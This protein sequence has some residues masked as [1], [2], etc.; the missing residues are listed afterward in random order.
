LT[1][2]T[3]AP[4]RKA[5]SKTT[6]HRILVAQVR[7][8]RTRNK[9]I[10]AAAHVFASKGAEAPVIDDFIQAAGVSRGTFYNYFSTVAE[11][12]DA[13]IAWSADEVVRTIEVEMK[14]LKSALQRLATACRLYLR[15]AG[16]DPGWC[17]FMAQLP[18]SGRFA[19]KRLK[20]DLQTG[21]QDG[22]F[23]LPDIDAAADMVTGTLYRTLCRLASRSAKKVNCDHTVIIILQGVGAKESAIKQA[24]SLPLPELTFRPGNDS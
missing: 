4:Q 13:T 7:R 11:L 24:M 3:Q 22:S 12:L 23:S 18:H 2:A 15:V 9:I 8:E 1:R 19:H 14:T 10:A 16:N 20:H 17:A 21:M 6:D 5:R